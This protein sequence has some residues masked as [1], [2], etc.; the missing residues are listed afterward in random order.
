MYQASVTF[1]ASLFTL[2]YEHQLHLL[3]AGLGLENPPPPAPTLGPNASKALFTRSPSPVSP[4]G[5][6][7]SEGGKGTCEAEPV[8]DMEEVLTGAGRGLPNAPPKG[9]GAAPAIGFFL[10]VGRDAE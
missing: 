10:G 1:K 5:V 4:T 8:E 3:P 6:D 9:V 7:P 2:R